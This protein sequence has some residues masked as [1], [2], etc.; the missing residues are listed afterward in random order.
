MKYP[1]ISAYFPRR[2]ERDHEGKKAHMGQVGQNYT[3]THA[4]WLAWWAGGGVGGGVG[5]CCQGADVL[6]KLLEVNRASRP[7]GVPAS[8]ED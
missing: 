6:W 8:A 7:K 4:R 2:K 5:G 3:G 1:L